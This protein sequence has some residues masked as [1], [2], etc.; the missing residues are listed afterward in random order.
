V[1][2]GLRIVVGGY[3]V[4]AP[5]GGQAWHYLQY[6]AGLA[7]LGHEILY[8]EDSCFF[9]D[10]EYEWYYDPRVGVSGDDPAYGLDF[11]RHALARFGVEDRWAFYEASTDR[12]HGPAAATAVS[13]CRDA[14]LFVNVSGINPVRPWLAGI[15]LRLFVDTDPCFTQIRL[16]TNP[17]NRRHALQHNVF[18]TFGE[19][20]PAGLSD[21]PDDSFDWIPTRQP[22]MLEAWP[23]SPG[24]PDAPLTAVM[25]WQT[26]GPVEHDGRAYGV[27]ADSFE[28]FLDLPRHRAESF[29]LALGGHEA[30][31]DV[32]ARNGWRLLDRGP[33]SLDDYQAYLSS[34]KAEFGIAKAGYVVSDCGWFSE[35]S[36][37]YLASGRPVVVQSTGFEEWLP[38][39]EGVLPFATPDEA[40]A[41]LDD[42]AT[43]YE[44]HCRAAREL[45]T[46][47]FD[48]KVVLGCLL[49]RACA[50]STESRPAR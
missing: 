33:T 49:E 26:Y 13:F 24:Q 32:L 7:A 10:D 14:D 48:H 6:I 5:L 44:R 9:E 42:L 46:E 20:I 30:P 50:T 19:N 34:S 37:G 2:D 1:A 45:V 27:K 25:A 16:L 21:L 36:A 35:R 8:I 40:T 22:M 15:P 4:R 12:W 38:S 28:P 18:A 11:V 47:Y 41:A 43:H 23:V 31:R 39:G 29:E 3:L 17:I